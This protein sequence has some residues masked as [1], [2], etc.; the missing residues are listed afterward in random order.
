MKELVSRPE[1][2]DDCGK[3]ERICP[4]NAIR[5]IS[6]VPLFCL[7]CAEDRAPCMTVCPEDA[8]EEIDGAIIIHEDDCIGC[9]LCR[10]SCPV[11]AIQ[12]NEYGI[13]CKCDLCQDQEVPLCVSVCPTEALKIS[14][15]DMLTEKRDRIAKELERVKMIMKY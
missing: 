1:L 7:H 9:G 11:G 2:C 3:C 6:G 8:I 4:K 12:L 15:E 10:D 5:V 13:A 14:S